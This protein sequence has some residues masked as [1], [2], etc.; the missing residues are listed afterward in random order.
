MQ[1]RKTRQV[2]FL[3][4]GYFVTLLMTILQ[5]N[6]GLLAFQRKAALK[7]QGTLLTAPCHLRYAIRDLPLESL[8]ER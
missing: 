6:N 4:P 3:G 5:E 2:D 1:G 8:A 7:G